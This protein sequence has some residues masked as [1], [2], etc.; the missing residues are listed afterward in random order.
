MD[1]TEGRL[2]FKLDARDG[3]SVNFIALNNRVL[4]HFSPDER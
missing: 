1:F 4:D 2:S 3:C